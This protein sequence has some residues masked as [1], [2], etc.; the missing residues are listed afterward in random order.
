MSRPREWLR[1][2]LRESKDLS[3]MPTEDMGLLGQRWRHSVTH[4]SLTSRRVG[5]FAPAPRPDS[6]EPHDGPGWVLGAHWIAQQQRDS[7]SRAGIFERAENL[8]ASD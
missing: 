7:G 2:C 5:M 6:A 4:S 3:W 1:F 8:L